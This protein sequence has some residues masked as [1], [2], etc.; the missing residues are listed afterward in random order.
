MVDDTYKP[1]WVQ[2][3][4]DKGDIDECLSASRAQEWKWQQRSCSEYHAFVIEYESTETSDKSVLLELSA[5]TYDP[6]SKVWNDVSG[7][8]TSVPVPEGI[9]FA[10]ES[11]AMVF[12]GSGR[13]SHA[14]SNSH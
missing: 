10:K 12:D 2:L 8:G 4:E 5:D 3:P 9:T 6:S 1:M 11:T 14:T 7:H 13:S